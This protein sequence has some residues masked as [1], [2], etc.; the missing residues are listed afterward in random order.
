LVTTGSL[1]IGL[2]AATGCAIAV[3]LIAGVRALRGARR[4]KPVDPVVVSAIAAA[5]AARYPGARV[6]RIE[7][8][9]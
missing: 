7:A 6:T 5:V 8:E 4:P 9:P 3:V 2:G 1:A